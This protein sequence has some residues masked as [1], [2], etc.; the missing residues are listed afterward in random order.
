MLYAHGAGGHITPHPE[1]VSPVP[2]CAA[3]FTGALLLTWPALYNHYPLL[4][5]DTMTYMIGGRPIAIALFEHRFARYFGMRSLVYT[6]GIYP[7]HWN[8]SPWPIVALNALLAAYILWLVVRS[9]FP[10]GTA[11]RYLLLVGLLSL[12]TSLSWYVSMAMPD[13]LGP[14]LY[15]S[16]YLLVFAPET[17]SRLEWLAVAVIAGWGVASHATHVV[18]A[19]GVC[20]LLACLWLLRSPPLKQRILAVGGAALVVL[21]ATASLLGLHTYLYG[22]QTLS[23]NMPPVLTARVIADGPGRWYL[24]RNCGEVH[25]A[26]CAYAGELP[27]SAENFLWNPQGVWSKARKSSGDRIKKEEIPFVLAVLRA[28]PREEMSIAAAS[29]WQQLAAFGVR[30]LTGQDW[31]L[32]A[33]DAALPG[34][35]PMY[36]NSGQITG[37]L[38]LDFFTALQFWTVIASV[39]AVALLFPIL[40][41]GQPPRLLGLGSVIFPVIIAN[42]LVT[43]ALALV[44][45]RYQ[46]RVIWLL[47]LFAGIL[48]FYCIDGRRAQASSSGNATWRGEG[49]PLQGHE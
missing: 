18:L 16:I 19:A 3:V 33:I 13:L 30:D 42:A 25:F 8:V 35:K 10:H 48:L 6:L 7:F 49:P 41:R 47:P 4:Y 1:R 9:L 14:L 15:L 38:P 32:Q 43:G 26:L 21:V 11:V 46:S 36:L 29:F 12:L 28:Y 5:P 34:K 39:A 40:S 44:E 31:T 2:R 27:G 24:Q 45:A 37:R 17:L 23:A 20:L 22:E